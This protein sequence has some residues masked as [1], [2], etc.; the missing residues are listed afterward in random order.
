MQEASN[1][2][3]VPL[4]HDDVEARLA[5][6]RAAALR[7]SAGWAVRIEWSPVALD[8]R[9]RVFDYYDIEQ[10]SQRAAIAVDERIVRQIEVLID[11]IVGRRRSCSSASAAS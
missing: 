5:T 1:D 11:S 4:P 6:R 10:E 7:R 3:R 2:P 9:D 8:D